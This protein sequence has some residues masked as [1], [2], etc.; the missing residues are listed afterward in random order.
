MISCLF[1]NLIEVHYVNKLFEVIKSLYWH[2]Q[3]VKDF[4][5]VIAFLVCQTLGGTFPLTSEHT[6]VWKSR[7]LVFY[8]LLISSHM[9]L[10]KNP[11]WFNY[12]KSSCFSW[13]T[14]SQVLQLFPMDYF[15]EIQQG[16]DWHLLNLLKVHLSLCQAVSEFI[17]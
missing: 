13:N 11:T 15:M 16:M 1:K 5:F 3:C 6:S 2:Y 9:V 10:K 12:M 4:F 17:K 7:L 8:I 14:K